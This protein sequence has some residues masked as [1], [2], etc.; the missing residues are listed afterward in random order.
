MS[1]P[2]A[3]AKR[4]IWDR[5]SS[6]RGL[7][8]SFEVSQPDSQSSSDRSTKYPL[9]GPEYAGITPRLTFT[10]SPDTSRPS[11]PLAERTTVTRAEGVH[12]MWDSKRAP[13]MTFGFVRIV[14]APMIQDR[15]LVITDRFTARVLGLLTIVLVVI[16]DVSTFIFSTPATKANPKFPGLV[17]LPSLPLLLLGAWL[18]W[19]SSKLPV[20]EE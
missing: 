12:A 4:A 11:S 13:K 8:P 20:D 16:I 6:E 18:L 15:A 10:G 7:A 17:I 5:S 14:A 1:T 19:R 2:S 9:R 3:T